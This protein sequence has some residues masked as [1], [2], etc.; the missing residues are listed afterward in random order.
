MSL[1]F[2][3]TYLSMGLL[4]LSFPWGLQKNVCI[5]SNLGVVQQVRGLKFYPILT[6]YPIDWT[7]VHIFKKS[8]LCRMINR[9]LSTVCLPPL[10]VNV[11]IE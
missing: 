7:I 6:P 5:F 10:L 11:V 9:G 8:T 2:Y 4:S 3:P 1:I